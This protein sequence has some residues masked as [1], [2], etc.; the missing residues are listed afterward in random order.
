MKIKVGDQEVTLDPKNLEVDEST[1]ND[2]LKTFASKYNYYNAMWAKAQYIQYIAED[3]HEA[4]AS[5][6]FQWYKENEGGSD[7][8]VEAKVKMAE[9]VMKAKKTARDAKYVSQV[10]FT[11]LRS[12]DKAHENALNL[13]YNVR[14]EMDKLFPQH[15]KGNSYEDVDAAVAKAIA[16][17][18]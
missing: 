13:G 10:L 7:K 14:K 15:I 5:E 16:E 8:L 1:M 18:Q 11:Y 17:D 2:F 3:R 12:M 9:I 6:R 4:I